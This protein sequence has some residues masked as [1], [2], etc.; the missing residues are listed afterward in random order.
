[1]AQFVKPKARQ[2]G[3][4]FKLP[5]EIRLLIYEQVFSS[6]QLHLF[7]IEGILFKA[8]SQHRYP[9]NA[10]LRLLRTCQT[11]YTEAK[12]VVFESAQLKILVRDKQF[13]E[14]AC[15]LSR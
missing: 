9:I 7:A 11:V 2:R 12:P 14:R 13:W 3:R 1:M 15:C 5:S 8:R 10:S 4:L 6:D